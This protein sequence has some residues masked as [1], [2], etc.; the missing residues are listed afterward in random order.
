MTI[1]ALVLQLLVDAPGHGFALMKRAADLSAYL[2]RLGHAKEVLT[3][4]QG[5]LYPLLD[6]LWREDLVSKTA[7]GSR[8]V[9]TLTR[10]GKKEA[11]RNLHVVIA[12]F[13]LVKVSTEF[14]VVKPPSEEPEVAP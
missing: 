5:T 7:E 2:V 9:W 4:S 6:A 12:V 14:E 8:T 1:R 10:R 11:A 3:L 13:K